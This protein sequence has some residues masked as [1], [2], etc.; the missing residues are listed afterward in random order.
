MG[1]EEQRIQ[2]IQQLQHQA[3][4]GDTQAA[5]ALTSL[6][7]EMVMASSPPP[8]FS[9]HQQQQHQAQQ[10]SQQ[11]QISAWIGQGYFQ[12]G[13][14]VKNFTERGMNFSIDAGM[15]PY[16]LFASLSM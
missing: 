10:R 4:Q 9:P 16:G 8:S 11:V 14:D 7:S 15:T 3:S 6:N 2:L 5:A 1:P 12:T 13:F